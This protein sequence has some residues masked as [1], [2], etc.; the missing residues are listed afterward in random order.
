MNPDTAE[1]RVYIQRNRLWLLGEVVVMKLM[2]DSPEDP[3]VA[4]LQVLEAERQKPTDSVEP[5][6]PE[7]AAEAK[8]YL[9]K[10]NVAAMIETWFHSCLENKPEHPLD[11][12]IAHFKKLSP[13]FRNE[14]N[15]ST[16][17]HEEGDE[18]KSTTG[19]NKPAGGDEELM[20]AL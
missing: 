4:A 18:G 19:E 14:D 6:T 7:D 2:R 11:F 12:S 1:N 17:G 5:P 8:E 15:I 9:Q 10:H 20:D 16:G 13:S 3:I